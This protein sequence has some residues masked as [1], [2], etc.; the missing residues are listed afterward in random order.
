MT[1]LLKGSATVFSLN[2]AVSSDTL[3]TSPTEPGFTTTGNTSAYFPII[4]V[5]HIL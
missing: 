1:T 4:H 5:G 3:C 2:F